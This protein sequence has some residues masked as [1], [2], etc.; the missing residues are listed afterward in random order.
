MV[1]PVALRVN[2]PFTTTISFVL[3]SMWIHFPLSSLHLA[4]ICTNTNKQ[5]WVSSC[6]QNENYFYAFFAS[7]KLSQQCWSS[8]WMKYGGPLVP[9]LSC[10]HL[11]LLA[12]KI[13]PNTNCGSTRRVGTEKSTYSFVGVINSHT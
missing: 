11:I 4:S 9:P 10:T 6:Q 12:G 13:S 5:Y 1:E 8:T 3:N 7:S 2:I